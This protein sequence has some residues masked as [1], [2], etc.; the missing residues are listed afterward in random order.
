MEPF[1]PSIRWV[2]FRIHPIVEI[3]PK[4]PISLDSIVQGMR[5][6]DLP[7]SADAESTHHRLLSQPYSR[8]LPRSQGAPDVPNH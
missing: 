6:F 5:L 8:P 3:P 4:F 7:P 1:S 2:G